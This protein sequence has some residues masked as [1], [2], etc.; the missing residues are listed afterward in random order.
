MK[1]IQVIII[2]MVLCAA[3]ASQVF[4][5]SSV[6][7][8]SGKSQIDWTD[9]IY[10]ATG[11]GVIPSIKEEPNRAKAYLKAKGYARMQAIAN[12]LAAIEGTTISFEAIGKDYM[13]D[14]VIR[15]RIEGYVRNVEVVDERKE[16]IEGDTMVIVTVRAPMYGQSAPGSVLLSQALN[17]EPKPDGVKVSLAADIKAADADA[18]TSVK[19]SVDAE[20]YTSV[21]FN[22]IGYKLDR[23]MSPKIRRAD[24]SEV[25]GTV[26]VDQDFVLEHGIASYATSIA[27][28]MKN[29][30]CGSNPLIIRAIGK[31]GGRFN[32]D[33]V[34]SDADAQALMAENAKCGFMDKLNVIIVEDGRL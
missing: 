8:V 4:C 34:I 16:K 20:P 24:G 15:Q 28:A 6:Q 2:C 32:S 29:S 19:P 3:M 30:R 5:E 12:L 18:P 11:E 25:W 10:T 23:C 26:K 13:E 27:E 22:T 17:Q 31:A 14:A 9:L 33:P 7:R 21:I 1:S